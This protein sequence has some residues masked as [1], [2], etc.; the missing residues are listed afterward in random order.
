MQLNNLKEEHIMSE[1]HWPCI[2]LSVVMILFIAV[3][4]Y[5]KELIENR[6]TIARLAAIVSA[7]IGFLPS[8]WNR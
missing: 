2:L 4:S 1:I 3:L 5:F 7:I 8:I 6:E